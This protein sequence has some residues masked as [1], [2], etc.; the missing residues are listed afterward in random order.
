M[1]L[2]K[3]NSHLNLRNKRL[4]YLQYLRPLLTYGC[5]IWGTASI[6]NINNQLLQNRALRIIA[7]ALIFFPRRILHDELRIPS[8]IRKLSTKFQAS[9]TSHS[10]PSIQQ[11]S[12]PGPSTKY[13]LPYLVVQ[14]RSFFPE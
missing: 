5:E 6:K 2:L 3:K 9:V 13:Q 10:N 12:N 1:P 8:H 7:K 4:I 11:Q 14:C